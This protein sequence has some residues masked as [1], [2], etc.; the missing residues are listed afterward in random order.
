MQKD[1]P[2]ETCN[3][4]DDLSD[5]AYAFA[6][7]KVKEKDMN[8]EH[9]R[10]KRMYNDQ[11]RPLPATERSVYEFFYEQFY[12]L[13]TLKIVTDQ[14]KLKDRCLS[15]VEFVNAT[16]W[17]YEVGY[18]GQKHLNDDAPNLWKTRYMNEMCERI[19]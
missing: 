15:L 16:S 18:L 13:N 19:S 1:G 3:F 12:V 17:D 6:S 11:D 9:S 4:P 7:E 8:P 10:W 2:M 14:K 5:V